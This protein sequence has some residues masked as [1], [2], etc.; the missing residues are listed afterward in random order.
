MIT[1]PECIELLKLLCVPAG[2]GVFTVHTGAQYKTAVQRHLYGGSGEL[3][4]HNWQTQLETLSQLTLPTM[5]LGVCSDVGGGIRR[6]ANW[7]PVFIRDVYYAAQSS[8]P[9][10]DLGDVRVIPQLLYDAHLAPALI[11]RCRKALYGDEHVDLP[12]SALSITEKVLSSLYE[13]LPQARVCALGGDHSVS[14]PLIKAYLLS[15]S[16]K[17]FAVIHFDAHTDLLV[18][19]MGVDITFA[20][21]AAHILPFLHSPSDLIQTGILRVRIDKHSGKLATSTQD[22]VLFEVFRKEYAPKEIAPEKAKE[23]SI[24]QED[25]DRNSDIEEIF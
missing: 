1:T 3:A 2:D 12:V 21:W 8:V 4:Q 20:S 5:L 9:L 16:S 25:D 7:G 17:R 18:E 19:R 11:K 10:L 22:D 23:K 13:A 14:Y 24:N 6:G 15:R